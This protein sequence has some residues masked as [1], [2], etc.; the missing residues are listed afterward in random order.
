M[1]KYKTG[2]IYAGVATVRVVDEQ[3]AHT[4]AITIGGAVDPKSFDKA[5]RDRWD[6][7]SPDGS[8]FRVCKRISPVTKTASKYRVLTA[9]IM[10]CPSFE[11][12]PDNSEQ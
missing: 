11:V 12:L 1:A 2:T 5:L 10:E 3:G 9:E 4:E 6:Y 8:E 7:E